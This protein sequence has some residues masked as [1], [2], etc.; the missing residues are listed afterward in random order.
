MELDELVTEKKYSETETAGGGGGGRSSRDYPKLDE[1][2]VNFVLAN[3]KGYDGSYHI[4]AHAENEEAPI[5]PDEV[6]EKLGFEEN[7]PETLETVFGVEIDREYVGLAGDLD[8]ES[9]KVDRHATIMVQKSINGYYSDLIEEH[10]PG[11]SISVGVGSSTKFDDDEK[12]NKWVRIKVVDTEKAERTRQ[13]ARLDVGAIDED[14]YVDW[15]VENEM[16]PWPR[17]EG[18]KSW[19]ELAEERAND[20]ETDEETDE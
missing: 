13:R 5:I 1:M 4:P 6:C 3:L 7:T 17:R 15:C 20:E 8:V 14:E 11:C 9:E 18:A 2:V 10:Y 19:E 16:D 12:R